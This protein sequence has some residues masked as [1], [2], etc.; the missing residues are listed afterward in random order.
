MS[1]DFHTAYDNIQNIEGGGIR[2]VFERAV[3]LAAEVTL[4]NQQLK[5]KV[6]NL[7]KQIMKMKSS[8]IDDAGKIAKLEEEIDDL[9]DKIHGGRVWPEKNFFRPIYIKYIKDF[10]EKIKDLKYIK[11]K[12]YDYN[13]I[14]N[15]DDMLLVIDMQK[16]FIPNGL[17]KKWASPFSVFEGQHI[18]SP[19]VQLIKTF[20]DNNKTVVLTRDYHPEDHVS[21]GRNN[22]YNKKY[23]GSTATFPTHCVQGTPGAEIIKDI[24][25]VCIDDGGTK[26]KNVHIVFKGY[27]SSVDSYGALPYHSDEDIRGTS[28]CHNSNG[29]DNIGNI[30]DFTGAV[31]LKC[32]GYEKIHKFKGTGLAGLDPNKGGDPEAHIIGQNIN[33]PPDYPQPLSSSVYLHDIIHNAIQTNNIYICGLAF[34]YCVLDSARNLAI[35]LNKKGLEKNIYVMLDLSRPGWSENSKENSGWFTSID[36]IHKLL[37]STNKQLNNISITFIYSDDIQRL[38]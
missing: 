23:P 18:V 14:G 16:D 35:Y 31:E 2:N 4:T 36:I 12:H 15:D 33:S 32:S 27:R 25:N 5:V 19:I 9:N 17:G 6:K 7:L 38:M 8:D 3:E 29:C 13:N 24:T 10:Q 22:K 30:F 1:K 28:L 21:F 34:D 26:R 20:N 37:E 11:I